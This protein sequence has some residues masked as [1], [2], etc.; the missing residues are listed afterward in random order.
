[1]TSAEWH[2]GVSTNLGGGT[3]Y[4]PTVLTAG[5]VYRVW[6]DITNVTIVNDPGAR[7]EPDEEDLFELCSTQGRPVS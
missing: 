4:D 5:A 1:M 3:V 2:I 7:V 6:I